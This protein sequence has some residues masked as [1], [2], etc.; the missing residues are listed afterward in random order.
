MGNGAGNYL[1]QQMESKIDCGKLE[2]ST[3]T[4]LK[5]QTESSSFSGKIS[6]SDF[7][8]APVTTYPRR[9]E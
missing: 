7:R 4:A 9:W 5:N 6:F 2:L 8:F 3:E 1:T